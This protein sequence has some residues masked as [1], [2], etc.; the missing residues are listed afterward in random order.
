IYLVWG[1]TYLAIRY[2]VETVPPQLMAGLRVTTP[3]RVATY[4]YVNPV[5]AIGLGA[6]VGNEPVTPGAA[7]NRSSR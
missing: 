4:A 2:A 1:S 6:V 5:V 7:G 3:A